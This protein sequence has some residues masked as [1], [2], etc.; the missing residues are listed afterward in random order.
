MNM[1][2]SEFRKTLF[3]RRKKLSRR[4]GTPWYRHRDAWAKSY[5]LAM[6]SQSRMVDIQ[7]RVSIAICIDPKSCQY[8]AMRIAQCAT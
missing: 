6:S 8:A 4:R 2:Y 3:V 1:L 5:L 7:Y